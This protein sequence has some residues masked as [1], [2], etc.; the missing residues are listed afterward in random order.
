MDA[1]AA[2]SWSEFAGATAGAAAALTGLVFV[3][4]S[5]N[6][7]PILADPRMPARAGQALILL[8]A[9][10]FLSLALLVPGQ[11][12]A[13]LGVELFVLAGLVGPLLGWLCRP[14][15]RPAHQPL[16]AWIVGSIGPAAVL[17]V[18]PLLAGLGVLTDSLGG[19]YW[20]PVAVAVSLLAGLINAWVL[21]I[22][23][24]R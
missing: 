11:P 21:L 23:I 2:E 7:Q 19:L 1:Y 20:L 15:A 24:L 14:A 6:L 18:S 22:E 17:T 4:V 10:V 9:P 12:A 3:A 5:I 8:A 16:A 13:A